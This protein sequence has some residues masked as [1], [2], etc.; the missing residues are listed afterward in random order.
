MNFETDIQT[1]LDLISNGFLYAEQVIEAK[2]NCALD[3]DCDGF[4]IQEIRVE[5]AGSDREKRLDAKSEGEERIL[6]LMLSA[7]V[8][9][10]EHISEQFWDAYNSE[11][12]M[13]A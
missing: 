7:V 1:T 6:W 12:R 11:M 3:D 2:I 8:Y 13:A 10:C 5:E 4:V 9:S